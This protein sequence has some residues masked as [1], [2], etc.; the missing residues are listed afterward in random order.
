MICEPPQGSRPSHL[1]TEGHKLLTKRESLICIKA[2]QSLDAARLLLAENFA[3]PDLNGKEEVSCALSP[4]LVF[5]K[6][7]ASTCPKLFCNTSGGARVDAAGVALL[8]TFS[9]AHV[10]FRIAFDENLRL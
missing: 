9:S 5:G 3:R 8:H 10:L 1:Q 6:G 2:Y 4:A 7:S